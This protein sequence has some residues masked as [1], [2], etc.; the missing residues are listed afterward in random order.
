L[1][2]GRDAASVAAGKRTLDLL[3]MW[4]A[5]SGGV[6]AVLVSRF[7]SATAT[8]LSASTVNTADIGAQLGCDVIVV[9]PNALDACLRAHAAGLP[10]ITADPGNPASARLL[11]VAEWLLAKQAAV[12]AP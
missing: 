6:S 9:V 8:N 7:M 5:R 2:S 11:Q 12:R 4:G 1:V 10:L 3:S